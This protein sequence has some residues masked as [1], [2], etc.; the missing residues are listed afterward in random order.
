MS[1][2]LVNKKATLNYF[3]TDTYQAGLQ[4]HGLEVKSLRKKQ[5]SLAGSFV[6]QIDSE[7]WL[8][9]AY[10]P[11]Y[12][13]NNTPDSYDPYRMRKLLIKKSE[14]KKIDMSRKS[15]GLTLIP[16]KLY[17]NGRYLKLEIA[18]ARGKKKFDKRET[19][20]KHDIDRDLGRTLKNR[21]K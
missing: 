6:V 21:S 8:K 11:P 13:P 5:G 3:V 14:L 15:A 17:N 4:L 18:L 7:L 19:L 12:Q 1:N 2:L 9:G 10:I 16:I 20:K